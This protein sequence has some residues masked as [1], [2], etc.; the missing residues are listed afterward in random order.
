MDKSG[1]F[2][3]ILRWGYQPIKASRRLAWEWGRLPRKRRLLAET[4]GFRGLHFGCGPFRM[5]GWINVDVAGAAADFPVDI[6]RPLRFSENTFDAMYGSEVF[7]HIDLLQARGFLTEARRVLR[8]GGIIRLTTP[9]LVEICR[10]Y[11][12][13]HPTVLVGDFREGWQ[14]GEFSPEIWVNS[15]F[16]GVHTNTFIHSS[17]FLRELDR[18]GFTQIRRC[19]PQVTYS[20]MPQ[21][22]NLLVTPWWKSSPVRLLRQP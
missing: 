15:I 3:S 13:V 20:R 1:T 7:E 4:S 10:I 11:L 5:Q 22:A 16:N 21:L 19:T 12:G 18:A 6:T 14:E 9:D 17:L 8:P 2:Y